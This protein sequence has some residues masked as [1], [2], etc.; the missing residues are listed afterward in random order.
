MHLS[1]LR[2]FLNRKIFALQK[3]NNI[4]QKHRIFLSTQKSVQLCLLVVFSVLLSG[5][6]LLIFS[7]VGCEKKQ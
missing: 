4:W 2:A 6:D 1:K 5:R 3:M 7:R